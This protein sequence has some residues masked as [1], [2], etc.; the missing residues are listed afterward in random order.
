M[1]ETHTTKPIQCHWI[2]NTHWDRERRFSM[3]KVR[4]NLVDM[5]GTLLD[6]FEKKPEFKH[7]HLD[8]QTI[9][10]CNI[11]RFFN[12]FGR[13]ETATFTFSRD[14][15]RTAL[16]LMDESEAKTLVADGR[17]LVVEAGAKKIVTLKLCFEDGGC[18]GER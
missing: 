18:D 9:P 5:M 2:S 3:Q 12:P 17:T 4:Y 10:F 1:L 14:I 16:C 6:I 15:V 11:V 8:S 7:F 13:E